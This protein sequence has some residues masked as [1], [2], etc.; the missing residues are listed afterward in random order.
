MAE[1]TRPDVAASSLD[2][3]YDTPRSP[4]PARAG[5]VVLAALSLVAAYAFARP[6]TGSPQDV[7]FQ[8]L[9]FSVDEAAQSVELRWTVDREPGTPVLCVV[10]S[11]DAAGAEVGRAEVPVPAGTEGSRVAMTFRLATAGV[12]NTG[13]VTDCGV[14]VGADGP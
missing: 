8:L 12:P 1:R 10:R 7:R 2:G 3:R 4:W 5:A 6:L 9:G 13:E 11:R 14:P